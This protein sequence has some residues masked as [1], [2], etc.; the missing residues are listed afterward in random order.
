MDNELKQNEKV[1]LYIFVNNHGVIEIQQVIINTNEYNTFKNEMYKLHNRTESIK[2]L[3]TD[4]GIE[5]KYNECDKNDTTIVIK[6]MDTIDN[7]DIDNELLYKIEYYTYDSSGK[8][9]L[10]IIDIF[11]EIIKE[12]NDVITN[13][14]YI[15]QLIDWEFGNNY[16]T[17][18]EQKLIND[19]LVTIK[20]AHINNKNLE[21]NSILN[22]LNKFKTFINAYNLYKSDTKHIIDDNKNL[23]IID[24]Q[25][26]ISS[27]LNIDFRFPYLF[28]SI[29]KPIAKFTYRK[30]LKRKYVPTEYRIN[31][32]WSN[33]LKSRQ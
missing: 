11:D 33:N 30:E 21:N 17:L 3:S 4:E 19:F 27:S 7:N 14:Y 10:D 8:K 32:I 16:K 23:A 5:K 29:I 2:E 26:I 1:G 20:I 28:K 9:I 24:L 22:L 31:K 12:P 6:S 18:M 13:T 25:H 15:K